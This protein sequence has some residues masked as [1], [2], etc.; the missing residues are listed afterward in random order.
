MDCRCAQAFTVCGRS[1]GLIAC[2]V[3]PLPDRLSVSV[4]AFVVNGWAALPANKR[5]FRPEMEELTQGPAKMLLQ[6]VRSFFG[7]IADENIAIEF[8][9]RDGHCTWQG[10]KMTL[11][12]EE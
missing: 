5:L 8:Y 7:G 6:M 9:F 1:L 2:K 10:G 3:T 4:D 12:G 11:E